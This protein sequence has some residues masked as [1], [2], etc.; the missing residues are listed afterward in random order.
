M[1][2]PCRVVEARDAEEVAVN[3]PIVALPPVR[4]AI[5]A[6]PIVAKVEV[7]VLKRPE[8]ML[9]KVAKRPVVVVV[10]ATVVEPKVAPLVTAKL[11]EVAF[12]AEKFCA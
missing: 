11:V 9:P 1:A 12:W 6:L 4:S 10:A 7:M 8:T 5:V 2:L 3:V